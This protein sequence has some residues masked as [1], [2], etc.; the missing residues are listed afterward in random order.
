MNAQD[1]IVVAYVL[2]ASIYLCCTCS[3][4]N[5]YLPICYLIVNNQY[6]L[7]NVYL[8]QVQKVHFV[9]VIIIMPSYFVRLYSRLATD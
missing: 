9:L 1:A 7:Q 8:L 5:S 4:S 2:E 3:L 6:Q